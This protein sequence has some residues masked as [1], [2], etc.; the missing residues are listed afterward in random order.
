MNVSGLFNDFIGVTEY[1]FDTSSTKS[2]KRRPD[3][4]LELYSCYDG[5]RC[6]IYRFGTPLVRRMG[7][8]C[9]IIKLKTR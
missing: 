2:S 5:A 3:Q 1:K 8:P 6:K 9:K 7:G 4:A